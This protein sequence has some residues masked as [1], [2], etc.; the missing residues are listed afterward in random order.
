VLLFSTSRWRG[1]IIAHP[2]L[3]ILAVV[4]TGNHWWFDGIVA[5]WIIGLAIVVERSL[6]WLTLPVG[7]RVPPPAERV[8]HEIARQPS[9]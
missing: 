5:W 3:T 4:A 6:H 7:A 8:P 2:V 1:L 9:M